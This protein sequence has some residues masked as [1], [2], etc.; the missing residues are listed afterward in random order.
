MKYFA[1]GCL[2]TFYVYRLC[3]LY[4]MLRFKKKIL[5]PYHVFKTF[6]QA[7]LS[8][9]LLSIVTLICEAAFVRP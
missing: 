9:M 8:H 2:E 4:L 3:S 7:M 6:M 5:I 1:V